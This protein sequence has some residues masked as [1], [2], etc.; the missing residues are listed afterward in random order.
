LVSETVGPVKKAANPIIEVYG[1]GC[2]EYL[3]LVV[4]TGVIANCHES[5]GM[6]GIEITVLCPLLC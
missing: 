5:T 4:F 3:V 6:C 2:R 1:T